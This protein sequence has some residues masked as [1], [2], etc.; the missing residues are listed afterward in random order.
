MAA[1]CAVIVLII[2]GG[3]SLLIMRERGLKDKA[4]AAGLVFHNG[5]GP[6]TLAAT[7]DDGSTVF[8][9]ERSRL[10]YS[11]SPGGGER[12]AFLSGKAMFRV[13]ASPG[14]PFII[15]TDRMLIEV[16]GTTLDVESVPARLSVREGMVKAGIPGS[17]HAVWVRRG[18]TAGVAGQ[19]IVITPTPDLSRFDRYMDLI[20]F[21]DEKLVNILNVING[22]GEG[23]ELN[24]AEALENRRITVTFAGNDSAAN[25]AALICN[26][27]EWRLSSEGS[28][29]LITAPAGR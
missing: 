3:A 8:L 16:T 18:E 7:L 11:E 15:S 19:H 1:A 13:A 4:P 28:R 25:I 21:K 6:A 24:A 26:A 12:R 23:P 29:L 10:E 5:Q 14:R 27:F 20:L 9:G 22:R 17:K 2:L